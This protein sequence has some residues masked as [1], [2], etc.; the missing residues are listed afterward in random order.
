MVSLDLNLPFNQ[1]TRLNYVC[2]LTTLTVAKI[3]EFR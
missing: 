1:E 2:Y 3:I